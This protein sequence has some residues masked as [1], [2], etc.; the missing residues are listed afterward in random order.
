MKPMATLM[1]SLFLGVF[2][3]V[4]FGIL[5]WA[6]YS[7]VEAQAAK[8]WPTTPGTVTFSNLSEVRGSKGGTTYTARVKYDHSVGGV[9]HSGDRIAFG[10]S[11]SSYPTIGQAIIDKI[12]SSKNVLFRYD[13]ANPRKATLAYGLSK[14]IL[15]MYIFAIVWLVFVSGFAVLV[16]IS[17]KGDYTVLETLVA[18]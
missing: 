15:M 17:A 8:Q 5:G 13:P 3:L 18:V 12:Q 7:T 2:F 4:G 6:V 10:Y 14:S 9:I 11:G 1:L 16:F